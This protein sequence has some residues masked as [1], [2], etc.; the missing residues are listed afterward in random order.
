MRQ[1]RGQIG[2]PGSLAHS[3]CPATLVRARHSS[4]VKQAMV[5]QRSS[6]AQDR[7]RGRRA[8]TGTI[9]V[10]CP[11]A[12][13]G[14]PVE[15]GGAADEQADFGLRGI[16]PLSFARAGP[17]EEAAEHGQ[18]EAVGPHPVQVGVAP[19]GRHRRFGKPRHLRQA[20]KGVGNRTTVRKRP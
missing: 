2:K 5:I 4:S 19:A 20:R 9:A 10:A 3:G 12:P 16:D 11:D 13:V 17:M 6:P 1:P 14:R 15:E 7:R 18:G 8:C